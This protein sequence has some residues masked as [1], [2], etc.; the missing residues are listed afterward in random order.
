MLSVFKTLEMFCFPSFG[1]ETSMEFL[2]KNFT[3]S[4]LSK[5][6]FQAFI[7]IVVDEAKTLYNL[8]PSVDEFYEF[9]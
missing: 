1:T 5:G 4:G 9:I 7:T 8:V 6:S 3:Q 2:F